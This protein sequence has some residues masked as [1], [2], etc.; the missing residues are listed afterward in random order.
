[1]A[2]WRCLHLKVMQTLANSI[3]H[4][5]DCPLINVQ[6]TWLPVNIV[7]HSR[8]IL[9]MWKGFWALYRVMGWVHC[10]WTYSSKWSCR[11]LPTPEKGGR[12]SGLTVST[13]EMNIWSHP[14]ISWKIFYFFEVLYVKSR[15][16]DFLH[17]NNAPGK[18]WIT[19]MPSCFK[20]SAFPI[21][22]SMRS[23]GE[24]MAP[25]LTITSFSANT[26]TDNRKIAVKGQI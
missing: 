17:T 3:K 11:L 24:L 14:S 26:W 10:C 15:H 20:S 19:G 7:S 8:P 2:V 9:T 25:P 18:C 13:E 16:K 21:P 6:V 12:Q 1:M 23:W 4:L 5:G 22:D